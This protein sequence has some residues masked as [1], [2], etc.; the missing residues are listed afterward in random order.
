MCVLVNNNFCGK[1]VSSL[2]LPITFDESFTVASV[3]FFILI[4]IHCVV[5]YTIS[6]LKSYIESFR[7]DII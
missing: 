4:L 6:R 1:L 3:P 2:E 5:N 7:I